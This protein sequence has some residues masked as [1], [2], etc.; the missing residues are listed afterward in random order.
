[1]RGKQEDDWYV[2]A[3]MRCKGHHREEVEMEERQK[4][5]GGSKTQTLRPLPSASGN[6]GLPSALATSRLTRA[7]PSRRGRE[8]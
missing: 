7:R 6:A 3:H 2:K 4:E 5:S 1:M 8:L